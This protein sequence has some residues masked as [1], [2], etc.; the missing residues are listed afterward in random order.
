MSSLLIV[1]AGSSSLKFAVYN[2]PLAE[3]AQ[4]VFRGQVDGIGADA[5]FFV[6]DA[7]GDRCHDQ[8]LPKGPD[9]EAEHQ[10]GLDALLDWLDAQK[11]TLAAVG[12]RVVHGGAN[13]AAPLRIDASN[14]EELEKLVPLAPLHQPHNLRPMRTL[15]RRLPDVPQVACFDTAFHRTQPAI[16]ETF[17][18]P[19]AITAEGVKR[20]GFHG[21]SYEYI[22]RQLPGVIGPRAD[23]AVVVAHLGNGAS[24]CAL[25]ERKAV[26]SS[27]GF[28]AVDGLMMGTRTGLLDPGVMLYLMDTRGWGSK[29]L[30][31]LIYKQSGL[32]GVSG[33]S[34]D[35][36]TLQESDAPE[37]KEAIELFCYRAARELG[38]L[39]VAAG[40]LDAIVFTGGIGEN[41]PA[42]RAGILA[43]LGFFGVSM[44]AE[45]NNTRGRLRI[46][47]SDSR[48]A[49]AVI[50]TDEEWMIAHHAQRLLG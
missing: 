27:M 30:T 34:Q 31:N 9:L 7:S 13:F 19:R 2:L 14:I 35:M 29:E 11:L 15:M 22:A 26:G 28:T 21:S 39:A 37:A 6:K 3:G 42:V 49:L 33:I 45:A 18:I 43:H 50:P 17:A 23:G 5:R 10:A 24:M 25:R 16:A 20:Y 36:R 44:D 47:K 4:A 32:L 8:E 46:D 48:V 1:N 12:H 38:S 40:G 41:S